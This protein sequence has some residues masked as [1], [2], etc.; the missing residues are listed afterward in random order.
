MVLRPLEEEEFGW[1]WSCGPE[2]PRML[3]AELSGSSRGGGAGDGRRDWGTDL[4]RPRLWDF[5]GVRTLL[6]AR[7]ETIC[8]SFWLK[9]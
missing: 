1:L 6:G 4:L 3:Q 5:R 9:F 7:L 2:I 8:I